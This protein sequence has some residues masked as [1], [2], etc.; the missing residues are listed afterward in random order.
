MATQF[1][2]QGYKDMYQDQSASVV[3]GIRGAQR[4]RTCQKCMSILPTLLMVG[5]AIAAVTVGSLA[6]KHKISA[7]IATKALIAFGAAEAALIFARICCGRRNS[8]QMMIDQGDQGAQARAIQEEHDKGYQQGVANAWQR[9]EVL[10]KG[11]NSFT[12]DQLLSAD[13]ALDA[14][15]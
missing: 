9:V 12:L 13:R 7:S 4:S 3:G 15:W 11:G 6:L 14:H 2:E 8:P 10:M 5:I 1:S